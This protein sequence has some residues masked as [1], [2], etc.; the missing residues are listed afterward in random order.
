MRKIIL[1]F[2]FYQ[3]HDLAKR[4]LNCNVRSTDLNTRPIHNSYETLSTDVCVKIKTTTI[5]ESLE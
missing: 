5:I 3:R 2:I 1:K 4:I